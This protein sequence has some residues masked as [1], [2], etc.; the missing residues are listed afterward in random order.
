MAALFSES[1][2]A[3]LSTALAELAE[4]GVEVVAARTPKQLY[5]ALLRHGL[6]GC[7]PAAS[8]AAVLRAR[9][10]S[11]EGERDLLLLWAA[12]AF[13]CPHDKFWIDP[14]ADGC[15]STDL[16]RNGKMIQVRGAG[17]PRGGA[18]QSA[19]V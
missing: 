6:G 15:E 13:A 9:G 12:V 8:P 17:S 11:F 5:S 2:S 18:G 10:G 4:Q 14:V 7:T 3:K 1:G 19:A 16:S